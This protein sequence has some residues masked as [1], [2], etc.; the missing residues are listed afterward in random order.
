MGNIEDWPL[1]PIDIRLGWLIL[2]PSS[3]SLALAY[4]AR[5]R[6][7]DLT[8][9][10]SFF[11]K[12]RKGP[13][14]MLNDPTARIEASQEPHDPV[15]LSENETIATARTAIKA[16]RV[17]GDAGVARNLDAAAAIAAL[18]TSL[19]HGEFGRF[20]KAE[21]QISSG[22]RAR[23]LKLYE[24]SEHVSD[25]LA[26]AATQKHR[27]AECQSASNLIKLVRDWL[28]RDE[29]PMP[30]TASRKRDAQ[31]GKDNASEIESV[32]HEDFDL[33]R[34]HEKT[35]S[36]LRSDVADQRDAIADLQR[37]LTECEQEFIAL[38]D[39]LPADTRE[40]AL[41]ALTS[42]RDSELAKIAK[43]FHWRPNDLRREL[44]D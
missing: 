21:L 22:Y 20:C 10:A 26:W 38:R 4:A 28:K 34:E 23:L 3:T 12:T 39:P 29:P 35:I 36:E 41:L 2:D 16:L 15:S 6:C 30:K 37:R 27:L 24:V 1:A 11:P 17:H 25:A 9:G 5:V 40:T 33:V 43:R 44:Q 8:T 14:P 31:P 18:K 7:A 42:S 13:L 19:R 32:I